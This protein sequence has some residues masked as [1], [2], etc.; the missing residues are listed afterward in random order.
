MEPEILVSISMRLPQTDRVT[1][2]RHLAPVIQE[3]LQVGG[4]TTSISLQPYTP[5]ED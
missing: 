1:L 4:Y 2:A 3:A 5:D